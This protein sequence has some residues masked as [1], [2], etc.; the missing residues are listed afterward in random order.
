M[1][2]RNNSLDLIAGIFIIYMI[3]LHICQWCSLTYVFKNVIFHIFSFFMFWFFFKSGMFYHEK[4]SKEVV[5]WG[6]KR[7][8]VPFVVFSIIGHILQCI[9]LLQDKDYNWMHYIFSPIKTVLV[10]GSIG[11]NYPL[12]FLFTLLVVQ[13]IFNYLYLK[14]INIWFVIVIG[15]IVAYGLNMLGKTLPL[16]F[17]NIP[18][19]IAT[20]GI[21]YKM[22]NAQYKRS[23]SILALAVYVV[24]LS[25]SYSSIDFRVN[26]VTNGVYIIAFLYAISGCIIINY[27]F[28]LTKVHFYIL[29]HIGKHSM[30]YYVMHWPVLLLCSIIAGD[31]VNGWNMFMIMGLSCLCFMPAVELLVYHFHYEWIFGEKHNT[32]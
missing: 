8:M 4:T 26:Q 19:G 22:K 20:Y 30:N 11:G 24:I 12:W 1:K 7:L 2:K 5:I 32:K 21:G 3:V 25:F 13:L 16:Y 17:A 28:S 10:D 15:F 18:L 29:E 6:G 9:R 14:K 31:V 23:V 27:L